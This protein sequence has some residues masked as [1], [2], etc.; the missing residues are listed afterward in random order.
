MKK[1]LLA[2]LALLSLVPA[3]F[4]LERNAAKLAE[5]EAGRVTEARL[6]WW[7]FNPADSTSI[8]AEAIASKASTIIV[9][10]MDSPWIT[11]PVFLKSN[12][13]L[14]FEDGAEWF[15]RANDFVDTKEALVTANDVSNIKI[16]GRGTKGG[17]L[18]M[19]KADYQSDRYRK[20]EWRHTLNLLSV[21]NAHIEK[22]S[23]IE[24]GGDGIYIGVNGKLKKLCRDIVIKDCICDRNHRQGISVI[25]C[26]N[27]LIENTRM[28]NTDGTA[29]MSGID[30]EPNGEYESLI[31]C[32]MRNCLTE[33]NSGDGYQFHLPNMDSK[34]CGRSSITLE[35]CV[36][37]NDKRIPFTLTTSRAKAWNRN[38]DWDGDVKV[39]NCRFENA[40]GQAIMFNVEGRHDMNAFIKDTKIVNPGVK[41]PK[42][43]PVVFVLHNND[44]TTNDVRAK[45]AFDNL[46]I[47]TTNDVRWLMVNDM[48]FY[49]LSKYHVSGTVRRTFNAKTEAIT[50][51]P[52]YLNDFYPGRNFSEIKEYEGAT[53]DYAPAS[54]VPSKL[55]H[56]K[57]RGGGFFWLSLKKGEKVDVSLKYAKLTT[58][59]GKTEQISVTYPSGKK[60]ALGAIDFDSTKDV[61]FT[62]AESGIAKLNFGIGNNWCSLLK[63]NVPAGI[64]QGAELGV[65]VIYMIGDFYFYLPADAKCALLRLYGQGADEGAN[66]K[67]SDPDGKVV[68]DIENLAEA[69]EVNLGSSSGAKPGVW[70]IRID[71]PSG[72]SHEDFSILM[73]GLPK[74]LA[75]SPEAVPVPGK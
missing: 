53:K 20:A 45:L 31:N 3:M 44:K 9:D 51:T 26:V 15:A 34:R 46:D 5:V 23:M 62:A 64:Y 40:K 12:L 25:A 35:N 50:V 16:I 28:T 27:L 14:I 47:E 69:M 39:I 17:T 65:N 71:K 73:A 43:S 58:N 2:V 54:D 55:A 75:T 10:K 4:A 6:S 68:L 29:P 63:S 74:F 70:R 42:A 22:M 49:G 48:A 18:R 57:L 37:R 32:V 21:E 52:K 19:R 30:F 60:E 24:S 1:K 11:G 66:V 56:V 8:I 59:G 13:T 67:V 72:L 38:H 7:G 33:G 41:F 61:S 36:S